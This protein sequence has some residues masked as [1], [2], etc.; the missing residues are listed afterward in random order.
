MN[1]IDVT[2]LIILGFFCIKGFFRGF[3]MEIFT[4][5]GLVL[6]YVIA[7]R[8][9]NSLASLINN[10]VRLPEL[11]A[12]TLSFFLI[13]ILVVLFCRWIAG[14]LRKITRWTLL[15]W[16]DR[17]GGIL[18]GLFKGAL[19]VSLLALLVS[20]I[21]TSQGM[22]T[23]EENSLLF[24]PARSVAPAV[25]NFI[26]HTFPQTKNFYD[27]V[28]EGLKNKSREVTDSVLSRRIESLQKELKNR[29][30]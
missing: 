7:I 8:Q 1:S 11:V 20:L 10:M 2:I 23:E 18:F 28:K 24:R 4:L 14:A 9:M 19:V 12:T 27:E 25:F 5:V 29:V 22:E 13:F 17:G 26:K 30:K 16:I 21:P 15:G 6:A 3:I